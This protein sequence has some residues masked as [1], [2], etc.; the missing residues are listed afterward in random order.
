MG[1]NG[2]NLRESFLQFVAKLKE[3]RAKSGVK[4][5]ERI[6]V[7]YIA[8]SL[9]FW[10]EKIRNTVDYKDEHLLRKYATER[11]LN[12]LVFIEKKKEKLAESL[13]TELIRGK[14]FPNDTI[15]VF[16]I[17]ETEEIVEKYLF[18][19]EKLDLAAAETKSDKKITSWLFGIAAYEIERKLIPSFHEEKEVLAEFMYNAIK[20]DIAIVNDISERQKITQVYLAIIRAILKA[21]HSILSF[22]L[23]KAHWPDW[24]GGNWRETADEFAKNVFSLKT[25]VEA[26]INHPLADKLLR[27]SKRRAV[28]YFIIFDLVSNNLSGISAK[29][30]SAKLSFLEDVRDACQA[31]YK[32]AR[33]TL[34][35][36]FIRS[37]IY[38]FVTKII[39]AF[40][41]EVPYELATAAVVNYTTLGIN[42]IFHPSLMYLAG[43]SIKLPGEK[44][45]GQIIREIEY[46]I[47]Q[48]KRENPPYPVKFSLGSQIFGT[49]FSVFYLVMFAI[50]FGAIILILDELKFNVVS[51]ALFIFFI[52]VVSFFA[53]KISQ[54]VRELNVIDRKDNFFGVMLD[55]FSIPIIN[56][57]RW[58]SERFSQVNVFVFALDFI[59]EAPFKSFVKIFDDWIKFLKEKKEEIM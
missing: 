36:S 57:G 42:V 47:Y 49:I 3:I 1:N 8:S 40:V 7:S 23:L 21:D 11:I 30:S 6:K 18:I 13:I 46:V 44:N 25:A 50:T 2:T 34:S 26:E 9:S 38:I 14:Y 48:K 39:L 32:K 20:N 37:V 12:R 33:E 43:S 4:S 10:Y 27:F 59:I 45:T 22:Y 41:L 51:G 16:K 17:Q 5:E 29:I 52:S 55:F 15:G 31:R 53:L 24:F 58:I 56:L 28:A 35:T 54:P 19:L